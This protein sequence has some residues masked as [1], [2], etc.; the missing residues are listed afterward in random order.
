MSLQVVRLC[1]LQHAQL[2]AVTQ[3]PP[4]GGGF[5]GPPRDR[6]AGLAAEQ[7][8]RRS[9]LLLPTITLQVGM[10]QHHGVLL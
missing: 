3:E 1:L 9:L 2:V 5:A 7:Q 10:L 8:L 6:H 4:D